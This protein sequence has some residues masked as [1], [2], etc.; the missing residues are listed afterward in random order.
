MAWGKGE[1]RGSPPLMPDTLI[2]YHVLID[3]RLRRDQ[4]ARSQAAHTR[5]HYPSGGR[6]RRDVSAFGPSRV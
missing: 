5:T 1:A 3:V 6:R 4:S 2:A